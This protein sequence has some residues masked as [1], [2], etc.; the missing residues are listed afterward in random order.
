MQTPPVA[1]QDHVKNC[2]SDKLDIST[3]VR[4]LNPSVK[5]SFFFPPTTFFILLPITTQNNAAAMSLHDI[6]Y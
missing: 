4:S 6:Q 5:K 2:N 1:N 3:M